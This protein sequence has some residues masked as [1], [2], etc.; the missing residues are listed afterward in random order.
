MLFRS[1]GF[2]NGLTGNVS[3]ATRSG[4]VA[5]DDAELIRV[6]V[7]KKLNKGASVYAGYTTTDYDAASAKAD[8]SEL[9]LGMVVKF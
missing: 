5:G 9:G 2:G 3:Y 1:M 6:A 4:D 7:M 8:T